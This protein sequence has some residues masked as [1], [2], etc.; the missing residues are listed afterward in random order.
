MYAIGSVSP[1]HCERRKDINSVHLLAHI[2]LELFVIN[3]EF[4]EVLVFAV[5]VPR[6]ETASH[7]NVFAHLQT[8]PA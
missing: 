3:N 4:F 7:H 2:L 1:V 6:G 5:F 8:S